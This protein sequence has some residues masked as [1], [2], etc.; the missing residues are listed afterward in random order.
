[1][2]DNLAVVTRVILEHHAIREHVKL[3]GDTVNDIE[4]LFALQKTQSG[5]GQ[6]SIKSL[7]EKQAQLLQAISF[8]EQGLKNHFDF[9]EEALLPLL[10]ELLAKAILH[11]HN[12]ISRQIN[13][14]KTTLTSM[15]LEGLEQHELLSKKS[16]IQQDINSLR[17]AVEEHAR[18]EEVILNMMKKA[19]EKNAA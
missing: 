16:V 8:L 2:P 13:S 15:K 14:A 1:M 19:L 7:T 5:W 4:A 6:T 17:Q 12:Q 10:G 3:A 11:E 9:E 18:H